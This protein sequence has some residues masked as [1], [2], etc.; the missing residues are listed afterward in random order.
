MTIQ[1][2]ICLKGDSFAT[3]ESIE[4]IEKEPQAWADAD[5]Q[6]VLEGMLRAMHRRKHPGEVDQPVVLRGLS[7]IVTPF[8]TGV[9]IALEI[10]LG[11]AVAGPFEIGRQALE[12][13]IR[14][15]LAQPAGTGASTIH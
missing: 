8:E 1:V 2:D 3:T 4:G 12:A 14:R 10:S 15:V 13:M 5:V 6:R 9:V 7:W 11:A